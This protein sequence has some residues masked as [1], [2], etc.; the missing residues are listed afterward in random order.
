MFIELVV[1]EQLSFRVCS[2]VEKKLL[3][4]FN[5]SLQS[6]GII[7][8]GSR[9]RHNFF[10]QFFVADILVSLAGLVSTYSC[11]ALCTAISGLLTVL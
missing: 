8:Q 11:L 7:L 2:V 4:F 3:Y 6:T 10:M 9:V 5:Y 1:V